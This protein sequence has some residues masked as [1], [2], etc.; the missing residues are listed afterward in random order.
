MKI[1]SP[2]DIQ[3]MLVRDP[4][5]T[6]LTLCELEGSFILEDYVK[7]YEKLKQLDKSIH[8][9]NA[10]THFYSLSLFGFIEKSESK[11]KGVYKKTD[12]AKK[13]CNH[14]KSENIS[15]AKREIKYLLLNNFKKGTLFQDFQ[16]FVEILKETDFDTIKNRYVQ[17]RT[18]SSLIEWCVLAGIIE[19]D[20]KQ[21]K[22]WYLEEDEGKKLKL[23]EFWEVF[24]NHFNQMKSEAVFGVEIFYVDISKIRTQMCLELEWSNRNWNK[25]MQKILNSKYGKK[26]KLYGSTHSEFESKENLEHKGVLYAY[27]GLD[28]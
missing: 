15:K 5:D 6:V 24:K 4:K 22:I 13:I 16:E 20:R 1:S 10:H 18:S 3:L 28:E 2:P 12:A 19:V 25:M 11:A 7:E 17:W 21:Q 9:K 23:S 14:F 26:I 27:I 8:I